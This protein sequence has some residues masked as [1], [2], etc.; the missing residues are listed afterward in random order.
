M[1]SFSGVTIALLGLLFCL[2]ATSAPAEEET[3]HY[4]SSRGTVYEEDLPSEL[5]KES[6]S[7]LSVDGE[8]NEPTADHEDERPEEGVVADEQVHPPGDHEEDMEG[9]MEEEQSRPSE[10]DTLSPVQEK[11]LFPKARTRET[12]ALSG[13]TYLPPVTAPIETLPYL[14]RPAE[15]EVSPPTVTGIPSL[16]SSSSL[17]AQ[18]LIALGFV[19]DG[20]ALLDQQNQEGAREL[21]ERAIGIAPFQPYSYYFL[22]RLAF[23]RGDHKQAIAFLQKA[24]LLFARAE[25]AWLGETI[26]LKGTVY[27]DLQD[28]EHARV[29]YQRS[30][31]FEPANLKVLSALARLPEEEPVPSESPVQ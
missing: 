2:S 22:G 3:I 26:S 21:F 6:P 10:Q 24:E 11:P 13:D 12:P 5:S 15:W 28:Y 1:R 17:P 20:K 19:E 16:P 4:R 23:A 29:A 25:R 9:V 14:S 30:L 31:R 8:F 7:S 18:E 27:E